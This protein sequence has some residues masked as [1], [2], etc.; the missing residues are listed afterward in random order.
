MS[1]E[2]A[3]AA[4]DVQDAGWVEV[5]REGEWG[6]EWVRVLGQ[7]GEGLGLGVEAAVFD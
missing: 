1:R 6:V 2:G 7:G 4:V 5:R 3:R